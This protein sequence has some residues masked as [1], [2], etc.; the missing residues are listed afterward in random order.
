VVEAPQHIVSRQRK[1]LIRFDGFSQR[2]QMV[3][4]FRLGI[5]RRQ[6]LQQHTACGRLA[7]RFAGA[8]KQTGRQLL[9][10]HEVIFQACGKGI[11]FQANHALIALAFFRRNGD[12]QIAVAHQRFQTGIGRDIALHA[13]DA[14]HLLA[15]IA[16]NDGKRHRAV[17]LQLNG[18][19]AREFQRRGQQTGGDQQLAQQGFHRHW[20]VVV[21]KYL[22]PGF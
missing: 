2:R 21:F 13:R 19:I 16:V 10:A 7:L 12:D 20:V 3:E 17:T 6:Y 9:G 1:E 15:V 5:L 18:D 4:V 8:D 11:T 14:A 22:F